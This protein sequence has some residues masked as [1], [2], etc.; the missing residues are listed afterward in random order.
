MLQ[1]DGQYVSLEPVEGLAEDFLT[2]RHVPDPDGGRVLAVP[3]PLVWTQDVR[4]GR[5]LLQTFAGLEPLLA[6]WLERRG[7]QVELTGDRPPAWPA[8][9]SGRLA[10]Y[11]GPLDAHLLD[12]VSGR[13]RGL[14]RHGPA[15]DPARLVAQVALGWRRA[16]VLVMATRRRDAKD[17]RDR[18]LAFLPNVSLFAGTAPVMA[19][20]VTV[21][22]AGY[23]RAGAIGIE[24]RTVLVA[25]DPAELFPTGELASPVDA[26]RQARRARLYG[27]MPVGHELPPYT[28]SLA[29]ALF[30]TDEVVVP[31]HGH[32]VRRIEAAFVRVEGGPRVQDD[33]P[34]RLMR[35]GVWQHPV[36]NRRMA[37]LAGLLAAGRSAEV[38]EQLPQ[39]ADVRLRRHG[40]RVVLLAANV[41]HALAL[42]DY[43]SDAPIACGSDLFRAGLKPEQKLT[44]TRSGCADDA[45]LVIATPAGLPTVGLIDVLVRADAGRGLPPVPDDHLV[46]PHGTENRLL[47]IDTA[48]RH[49][50]ALRTAAG[51]RKAAYRASGW[52]IVGEPA[53][54]PLDRFLAERPEV[55]A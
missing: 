23:A 8:P 17:F 25:L 44:L 21:A 4:R 37:R 35:S 50:P 49:H 30:G 31:R 16:R 27:I 34:V 15:V 24:S 1:R 43:L 9:D 26:L 19:G 48:D 18:L 42:A 39:L 3:H 51:N 53:L 38:R 36:R 32:V 40:G 46:V 11:E 13:D 7:H 5:R 20:R 52:S 29:T 14:V 55:R 6:D 2:V 10:D 22:T 28:R 47:V 45:E 54:S 41:E 33:D 12:F